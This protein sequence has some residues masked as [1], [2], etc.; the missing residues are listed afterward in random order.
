MKIWPD[1]EDPKTW[2][3]LAARVPRF[4]QLQGQGVSCGKA[5]G[6]L[7]ILAICNKV[8]QEA[9]ILV[10]SESWS[11][12]STKRVLP[13]GISVPGTRW[14]GGVLAESFPSC[15]PPPSHSTL[16]SD[17]DVLAWDKKKILGDSS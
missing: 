12:S 6:L 11:S 17:I 7:G 15:H 8:A 10:L 2:R 16:I 13:S 14:N 5:Y 1:T 4:P 3:A 9:K